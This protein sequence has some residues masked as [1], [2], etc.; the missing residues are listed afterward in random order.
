MLHDEADR[1]VDERHARLVGERA[2]RDDAHVVPLGHREHVGL[3]T[4]HQ[5]RVQ[6]SSRRRPV[7]VSGRCTL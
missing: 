1:E 4:P 5:Q 7:P 3:D 6:R 2:P